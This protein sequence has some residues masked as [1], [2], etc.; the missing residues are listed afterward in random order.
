MAHFKGSQIN[1]IAGIIKRHPDGYGFLIPDDSHV[2]DVYVPKHLMIGVMT[3]DRVEVAVEK[4]GQRTRAGTISIVERKTK[5]VTGQLHLLNPS[6]GLLRDESHGWGEALKVTWPPQVRVKD[7]EWIVAKI[8]SYPDSVRGFHGEVEA[9]IGDISDP[10]NDN[11]RVMA[12]HHIPMSFSAK[13]QV[14]RKSLPREVKD[15]DIGARRDLRAS[16]FVTIDGQTA[17]D[18][19]D[20][21]YTEKMSGGFRLWV[22]IAD[23]SHYVRPGTAIDK[24]AYERGTS[25][26]FPNFVEPMLPEELSNELCSLKPNVPRFALV[27]EMEFN[28]QGQQKGQAKMYEAV[29][30]S[31]ARVTY[32][33]AQEA[34]DGNCPERLNHVKQN[35]KSCSELAHI[36]MKKRFQE[37]SLNLEIPESTIEL[38]ESGVPVDI[39]RAERLFAHRLIEEL[40]LAA[41]V[42]VANFLVQKNVP[43]LFRIHEPPKIDALETLSHFLDAFGYKRRLGTS[44]IQRRITEMLEEFAGRPEETVVNILTLRSMNQAKYARENVGHFGLGFKNYTHF[45]SPIRRYPDLIVHRLV[46]AALNVR[47]YQKIPADELDDAGSFLSACEQRS[48]KAER[49]IHSIKKARFL[50]KYVGE[51]FDGMISSVAKFGLFVTL[52]Q[53]DVDGLVRVEELGHDHFEFDEENLTLVGR[54]SKRRYSIG[55]SIRIQVAAADHETGRVDFVLASGEDNKDAQK[56]QAKPHSKRRSSERHR[57]GPRQARVSR[58]SRTHRSKKARFS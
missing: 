32:G 1:K 58:R 41:N 48:V 10:Q 17:K 27:A 45:T 24:D 21:V 28:F 14:E 12:S 6:Q 20:A 42:A 9:V 55:E 2:P 34:I 26:Y 51:E 15:S 53:F 49:Q 52:R 38:D 36:L 4:D 33:E 57:R 25:V 44:K 35:I 40:M 37:G 56:N 3:N 18:F 8:T 43:A 22:A 47:G 39:I 23:V 29:I 11:M 7:K 54:R 16:R 13:T 30:R 31:H 50:K 5:V 46:K 19:D